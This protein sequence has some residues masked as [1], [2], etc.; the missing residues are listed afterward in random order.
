MV[1]L[2]QF[3]G[4][5]VHLVRVEGFSLNKSASRI[6]KKPVL[7]LVFLLSRNRPSV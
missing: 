1:S 7:G 4:C 3:W 2:L 5:Y 6:S